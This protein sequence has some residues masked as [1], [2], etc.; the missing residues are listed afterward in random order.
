MI[1]RIETDKIPLNHVY[2]DA[3]EAS[4]R[5]VST[6]EWFFGVNSDGWP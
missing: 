5:H 6:G 2:F 1:D 3:S 4:Y